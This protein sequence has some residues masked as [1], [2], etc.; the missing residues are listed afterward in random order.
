MSGGL[1]RDLRT[2]PGIACWVS[3]EWTQEGMPVEVLALLNDFI[4]G[5][6]TRMPEHVIKLHELY[7][8]T[9]DFI[10]HVPKHGVEHF[11]DDLSAI[12]REQR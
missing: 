4:G 2:V 7:L 9:C 6:R 8:R 12:R 5:A 1:V 3:E 10:D 11:Q